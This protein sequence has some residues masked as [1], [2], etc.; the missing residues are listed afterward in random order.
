MLH[1]MKIWK[2]LASI[3]VI[4]GLAGPAWA[5]SGMAMHEHAGHQAKL[6]LNDGNKWATDEPLR[7]GMARIRSDLE[8]ALHDIHEGKL[9]AAGY[10]ALADQ[11]A[12]QIAGIVAEC[13]LEPKADAQLHIVIA[14][15]MEGVEAMQGKQKK[16]KRQA[17]AVTVLMAIEQYASYFDDRAFQAIKH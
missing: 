4:L 3:A 17:G 15:M 2:L 14:Q 13:K 9:K 6:V 10:K 16:I 5:G 7:Q 8:A 1:T 12:A 11:V